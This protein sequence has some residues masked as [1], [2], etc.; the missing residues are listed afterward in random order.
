MYEGVPWLPNMG[1]V[2]YLLKFGEGKRDRL[3][4]EAKVLPSCKKS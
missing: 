1:E 3:T 2:L 4:L